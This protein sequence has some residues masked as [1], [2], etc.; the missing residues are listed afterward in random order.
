MSRNPGVGGGGGGLYISTG[1]DVL[2][3]RVFNGGGWGVFHYKNIWEGIQVYL[4]GKGFISVWKRCGK[5]P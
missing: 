3:K 1:R 4:S 5:L 2:T